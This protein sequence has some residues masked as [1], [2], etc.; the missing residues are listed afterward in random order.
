MDIFKKKALTL[1]QYLAGAGHNDASYND[2]LIAMEFAS[3]HHTGFRKDGT[4]PE[5]DH[6]V[7]IALFATTLPNLTY[8]AEVITTIFYHDL[9]EDYHITEAEIR[10][11][12]PLAS[13]DFLDRVCRAVE[14][15]TKEWRGVKKDEVQLFNA[16]ADDP[17]ASISKGCD[18]I[19]NFQSMVGVF[20]LSKQK[21]YIAEGKRLFL[22]MLKTARKQFTHQALAYEN[23]KH[24]LLSQ[25]E[26]IEAMHAV[27]PERDK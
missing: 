9:R 12:H 24:M 1:R 21:E 27:H 4:T 23:I 8:R 22:P 16:M 3:R 7:S 11:K 2:A 5:F 14:N 10:A 17:V 20:K 13:K 15:M 19:H 18:R 25:I 6:Q 26:L